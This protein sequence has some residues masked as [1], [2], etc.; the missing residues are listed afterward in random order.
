MFTG[1]INHSTSISEE[2]YFN[3]MHRN[4]YSLLDSFKLPKIKLN[5]EITHHYDIKHFS[6]AN[7]EMIYFSKRNF[8]GIFILSKC[9]YF[10]LILQFSFLTNTI[11]WKEKIDGK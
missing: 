9:K 4:N 2:I 11:F 3:L 7:K 5:C 10:Y 1:Q 8:F 6:A